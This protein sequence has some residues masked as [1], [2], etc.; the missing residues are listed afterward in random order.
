MKN[1]NPYNL[2][3]EK[4]KVLIDFEAGK[5]Q[6]WEF[7][8]T[9]AIVAKSDRDCVV[10]MDRIRQDNGKRVYFAGLNTEGFMYVDEKYTEPVKEKG[11]D[12]ANSSPE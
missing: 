3:V 4:S 8:D 1:H 9:V 12:S 5:K 6:F 2:P 10:S 7:V 11:G